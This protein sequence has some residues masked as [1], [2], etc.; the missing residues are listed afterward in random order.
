[1]SDSQTKM[2]KINRFTRR[3]LGEEEVYCFSAIL[4]DNEID[5]D[6]EKFSR[7][8]LEKLAELF[9]GKT[10]IF[11]HDP[12]GENQTARIFDA[13]VVSDPERK[14]ADGEEYA[15]LKAEA[16]MVRTDSNADLI[17]EIDGGIKKEVSVGCAVSKEICSV[18]GRDR[19]SG[20][21]V[22]RKG[23]V[24]NGRKCFYILSEP[25]DAYEWSF[26]A[27]PAQR[28][29]GV[30]KK[31]S[32]EEGFAEKTGESE[33]IVGK[34]C[35]DLRRE[36]IRL[37]FLSGDSIPVELTKA[38]ITRMEPEELLKMKQALS[39][40]S[41]GE[42]APELEKALGQNTQKEIEANRSFRI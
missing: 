27:V 24:Y 10:G 18:C 38:A 34:L 33:D 31:F 32:G 12:K 9:I 21:C 19:R 28:G 4:C 23:R 1:M 11:N 39:T 3:E 42:S 41:D 16:Y 15:C 30:T 7:Q 37:S 25:T 8:A 2:A 26:V 6:Q 13:K 17:R 20:G 40:L 22:H 36:I 35:D 5:R 14:T 29:A